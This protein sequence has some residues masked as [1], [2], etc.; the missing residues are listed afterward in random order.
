MASGEIG[1]LTRH[2]WVT[3][4]ALTVAEYDRM[5]EVGFLHED[6]RVELIEVADS[7]LAYDRA[8]QCMHATASRS[9]GSS[10]SRP[11]TWGSAGCLSAKPIRT[12]RSSN[13]TAH[14][15]PCSFLA[16]RCKLR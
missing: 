1:L 4:R 11:T 15:N 12:Y 7:S 5:G 13:A 14:W 6:D 16:L 10:T 3:R 8:V 2:P 9:S